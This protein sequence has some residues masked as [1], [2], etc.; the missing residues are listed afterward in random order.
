MSPWVVGFLLFLLVPIILSLYLAF[1]SYSGLEE[2]KWIGTSNF[3]RMMHDEVFWKALKNT[4]LYALMALPAGLFVSLG[5]ALLLPTIPIGPRILTPLAEQASY[6]SKE[7]YGKLATQLWEN[8]ANQVVVRTTLDALGH[9][10]IESPSTIVVG[11]VAAFD[12]S[13]AAAHVA[14]SSHIPSYV[15]SAL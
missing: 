14:A 8:L 7:A 3:T 2:P 9:E 1:T 5:L 12:F 15:P 10:H 11:A 4:F 13:P 6:E